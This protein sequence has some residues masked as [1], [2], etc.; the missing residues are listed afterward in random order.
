MAKMY[1]KFSLSLLFLALV[2]ALA[3]VGPSGLPQALAQ[4]CLSHTQTRQLISSGQIMPVAQVRAI[5]AAAGLGTVQSLHL[6]PYGNGFVYRLVAVDPAG[7]VS[8]LAVNARSGAF[9]R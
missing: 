7:R 9:L 6:C 2:L 4:A 5:V 8:Q 1:Q 3:P